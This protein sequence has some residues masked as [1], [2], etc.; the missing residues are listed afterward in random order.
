MIGTLV[1]LKQRRYKTK[2]EPNNLTQ[3]LRALLSWFDSFFHDLPMIPEEIRMPCQLALVE[4]FTN[5]VFH[6]HQDLPP[7][8][9]IEIEI[10]VTT[11]F[12]DMKIWDCGPGFDF[13]A[14]LRRKLQTTTS[15]SENGRG[16]RIM[17]RI[18]E[19]IEYFRTADQRNCLHIRKSLQGS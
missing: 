11:E 7:E 1:I 15:E 14:T 4:G 9:L 17:Y 5:V 12:L 13:E 6:A 18:A 2:T 3:A 8:T 19:K 16:L 10:S